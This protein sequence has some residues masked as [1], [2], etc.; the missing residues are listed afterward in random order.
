MEVVNK[1]LLAGNKF[2]PEIHLKQPGFTY[3]ACVSFTKN[4][5]RIQKFKETVDSRYINKNQLDKAFFQHDMVDG[6]FKDLAKR[7]ASAKFHEIKHLQLLEIL[8][9]I[10]IKEVLNLSFINMLI[11]KTKGCGIKSEFK[12]NQQ[13]AEELHKP[14]IRNF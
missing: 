7:T 4:K 9:M 10:D 1:F 13:L 12:Q 11:R 8:N 5:W 3:G 14:I 6:H 2:M